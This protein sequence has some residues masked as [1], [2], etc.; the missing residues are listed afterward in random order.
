MA[1]K[2][3]IWVLRLKKVELWGTRTIF[4]NPTLPIKDKYTIFIFCGSTKK[5]FSLHCL[6]RIYLRDFQA[7]KARKCG[8]CGWPNFKEFSTQM[9]ILIVC[10]S[11][12]KCWSFSAKIQ[13]FLGV[14]NYSPHSNHHGELKYEN[15]HENNFFVMCYDMKSLML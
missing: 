10:K 14:V 8:P 3:F 6:H 7:E 13:V 5:H 9:M 15:L 2:W 12:T 11:P 4:A 1:S